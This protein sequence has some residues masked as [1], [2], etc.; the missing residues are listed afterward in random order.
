MF[1]E[2]LKELKIIGRKLKESFFISFLVN[3]KISHEISITTAS[4]VLYF[5]PVKMTEDNHF[6]ILLLLHSFSNTFKI[7]ILTSKE[8]FFL[9][10]DTKLLLFITFL[11]RKP[12]DSKHS[13]RKKI[14][15][16][17]K[18]KPNRILIDIRILNECSPL[19]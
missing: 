1:S 3:Q 6:S 7:E 12:L 8:C 18:K 5:M 13:S 14:Y 15:W 10:G 17:K 2:N 11:K 4:S 9:L 19:K 16:R